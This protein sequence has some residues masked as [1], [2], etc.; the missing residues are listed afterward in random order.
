[1]LQAYPIP[2]SLW[3]SLEAVLFTK[4]VALAKEVAAELNVSPKD[5]I[6]N[7]NMQENSKFILGSDEDDALY[8]CQALTQHGVVHM[9]CR[10]PALGPAPRFCNKHCQ[11]PTEVPVLPLVKR[12]VTPE[13][14]YIYNPITKDVFTL[15]GS[16]CGS[17]KGSKLVLF[18][19]VD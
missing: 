4:G 16:L 14:T 13:A 11:L 2:K 3:E 7:L 10:Y 17:F 1:M 6:A 12:L 19:I 8:Q 15:N 5:I 18:E 9:R